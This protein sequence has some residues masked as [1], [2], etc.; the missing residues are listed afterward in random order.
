MGTQRLPTVPVVLQAGRNDISKPGTVQL[1]R[2]MPHF[3]W[4]LQFAGSDKNFLSLANI[5]AVSRPFIGPAG[6]PARQAV[7]YKETAVAATFERLEES[8]L[9][10]VLSL[11][12]TVVMSVRPFFYPFQGRQLASPKLLGGV[13]LI[14]THNKTDAQKLA[15]TVVFSEETDTQIGR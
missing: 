2:A 15:F 10:F 1:H 8:L 9:L 13:S 12:R 4:H 3:T 6:G 14:L 7:A 11:H 5:T